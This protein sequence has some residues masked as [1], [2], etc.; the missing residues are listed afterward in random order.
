MDRRLGRCARALPRLLEIEGR[1]NAEP[2]SAEVPKY[3]ASRG[4]VSGVTARLP[5]TISLM[6][7]SGTPSAFKRVLADPERPQEVFAQ[8]L[9]R[10]SR[11]EVG[12]VVTSL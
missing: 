3:R 5:S 11:R 9:A 12:H 8:D 1:L 7:F 2:D 4:A 6:R 10:V